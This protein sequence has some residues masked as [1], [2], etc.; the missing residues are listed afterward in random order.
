MSIAMLLVNRI[1]EAMLE[2]S[3]N[4]DFGVFGKCCHS[5]KGPCTQDARLG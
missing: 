3:Q 4:L 5:H 2:A 1:S